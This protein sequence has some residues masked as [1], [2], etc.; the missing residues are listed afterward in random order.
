MNRTISHIAATLTYVIERL[1]TNRRKAQKALADALMQMREVDSLDEEAL[2][3]AC[4]RVADCYADLAIQDYEG[5][6]TYYERAREIKAKVKGERHQEVGLL[7][8][9]IG[10]CFAYLHN[11]TMAIVFFLEALDILEKQ[12]PINEDYLSMVHLNLANVYDEM[13]EKVLSDEHQNFFA[14]MK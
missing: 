7:C 6:W 1:K 5:A 9:D 13:G 3:D 2:A 12:V 4:K 8:N 14:S 11:H 10:R